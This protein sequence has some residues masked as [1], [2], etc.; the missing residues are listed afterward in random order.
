MILY[1]VALLSYRCINSSSSEISAMV[2]GTHRHRIPAPPSP[3]PRPTARSKF[4]NASAECRNHS[5]LLL[6]PVQRSQFIF[7]AAQTR[8]KV[9]S[10]P[11]AAPHH[12][13]REIVTD[14]RAFI[15]PGV[16]RLQLESDTAKPIFGHLLAQPNVEA[17]N[18]GE[19]RGHLTYFD[20]ELSMLSPNK[21]T[22][23]SRRR[24]CYKASLPFLSPF[25][26]SF[27]S[28]FLPSFGP[29]CQEDKRL[30]LCGAAKPALTR[31][32]TGGPGKPRREWIPAFAGMTGGS[33]LPDRHSVRGSEGRSLIL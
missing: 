18:S 25:F 10:R 11:G 27:G 16:L 5:S 2:T 28:I 19:F 29:P 23:H 4:R 6:R 13:T 20:G 12:H 26:V 1:S 24:L 30:R 33:S 9:R 32:G 14:K 21:P 8:V 7:L 31:S 22:R 17:V 15:G 3:P